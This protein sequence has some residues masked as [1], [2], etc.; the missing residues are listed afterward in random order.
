M[1]RC[2]RV[3]RSYFGLCEPCYK[4]IMLPVCGEDGE[5]YFNSCKAQEMGIEVDHEGKC[6]LDCNCPSNND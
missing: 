2:A 1:R 5:T 3:S 4:R 6:S